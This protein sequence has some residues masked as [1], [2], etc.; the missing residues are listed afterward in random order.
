MNNI[1]KKTVFLGFIGVVTSG[2]ALSAPMG[3]KVKNIVGKVEA[4]SGSGWKAVKDGDSAP[5]GAP[6]RT[7]PASSCVLVWAG[8]NTAKVGPLSN[9]KV[10]AVDKDASGKESSTLDLK[11]GK[12]VAHAKKLPTKDSSF[13]VSTPTA[14]AGVRGTDPIVEV[15]EG[16]ESTFGVA[17]GSIELESG[18]ETIVLEEGFMVDVDSIGAI[19]E[20][21][22]IPEAMME[23]L[24]EDLKEVN[25]EAKQ[26]EA[27]AAGGMSES[28]PASGEKKESAASGG[29]EK[30][31][32]EEKASGGGEKADKEDKEDKEESASA[33][34]EEAA[35]G[36]EEIN[37][38]AASSAIDSVIEAAVNSDITDIAESA[39]ED[40][41]IT[42]DVDITIDF[43][44]E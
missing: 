41:I 31:D 6:L 11:Q 27:E 24:K 43:H 22:V 7:G 37:T 44:T 21:E 29:G 4:Q 14:V 36:D 17:A 32:K 15:E 35:S 23:E 26:A 2:V 33:E 28:A 18:G 39:G 40:T 9:M 38:D 12:I 10:M 25:E 8:G 3:V 30:E 42:G 13:K 19:A 34:E 20:P 16:G 5:V 1:I